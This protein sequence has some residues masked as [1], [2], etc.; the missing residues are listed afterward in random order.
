MFLAMSKKVLTYFKTIFL[1]LMMNYRLNIY[2]FMCYNDD[3]ITIKNG[4]LTVGV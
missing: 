1:C 4:D 2:Y 3:R